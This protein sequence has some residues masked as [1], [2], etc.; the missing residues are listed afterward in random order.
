[1]TGPKFLRQCD[2]SEIR[3]CDRYRTVYKNSTV[4]HRPFAICTSMYIRMC[5]VCERERN[6]G[7][8]MGRY[9]GNRK[10]Q[11][12]EQ[13][14]RKYVFAYC[15][16][17]SEERLNSF[18][19]SLKSEFLFL[20]R[21][22]GCGTSPPSPP[23]SPWTTSQTRRTQGTRLSTR[24]VGTTHFAQNKC[25]EKFK[26]KSKKNQGSEEFALRLSRLEKADSGYYECQVDIK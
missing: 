21:W 23:S 8:L 2:Q 18:D 19:F 9:H 7:V 14:R 4:W 5:S 1:M 6:R 13:Q 26:K 24:Q 25:N 20:F 11:Q 15:T 3:Q 17:Q 10:K 16:M 22:A 12:R